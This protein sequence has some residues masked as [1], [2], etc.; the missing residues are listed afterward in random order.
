MCFA[1]VAAAIMGAGLGAVIGAVA[2]CA[3]S[4]GN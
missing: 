3:T 2:I 4:R 1:A